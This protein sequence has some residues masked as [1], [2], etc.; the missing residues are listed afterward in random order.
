MNFLKIMIVAFIFSVFAFGQ[1]SVVNSSHNLSSSGPVAQASDDQDR[2]CVFCHTPHKG[3][4]DVLWNRDNP[5]TGDFLVRAGTGAILEEG[6]LKCLSC[7]DGA[8]AVNNLVNGTTADFTTAMG[9]GTIIGDD[10]SG[11]PVLVGSGNIGTNLRNDHPVGVDY[12][13]DG[14]PRFHDAIDVDLAQLIN[15][16]V[17]CASCHDPHDSQFGAFLIASNNGSALCLDCHDR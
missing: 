11:N 7:H 10:G 4:E 2:I 17:A 14:T 15:S 1:I 12:P 8:T 16:K 9:I 6:S 13:I 3:S 5:V